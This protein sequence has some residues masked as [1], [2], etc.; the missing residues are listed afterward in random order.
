MIKN[1]KAVYAMV[2]HTGVDTKL[3]LNLG[4]YSM[5]MSTLESNINKIMLINLAILIVG[6]AFSMAIASSFLSSYIDKYL[7]IFE[8][9]QSV[10]MLTFKSFW[11]FYL[12]L[13]CLIPLN[14]VTCMELN[15]LL[16]TWAIEQDTHMMVADYETNTISGIKCQTLNLHEDL[17]TIEY[18]FSDKTGTLTQNELLFR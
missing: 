6:S 15:K 8:D 11:S 18:I 5:K 2:I 9:S 16:Q 17:G 12:I 10:G 14:L 13:N 4:K 7:Y 1:S 3:I